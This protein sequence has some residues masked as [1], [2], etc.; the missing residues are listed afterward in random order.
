MK[1]N[2]KLECISLDQKNDHEL[3]EAF[4]IEEILKEERMKE[5]VRPG[6]F[7]KHYGFDFP[8][9]LARYCD[10]VVTRTHKGSIER[11]DLL[12]LPRSVNIFT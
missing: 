10:E 6:D 4:N 5:I 12:K 1:L 7:E 3:D 8:T 9:L 11:I 2:P